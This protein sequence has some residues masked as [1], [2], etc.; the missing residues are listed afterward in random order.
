[1]LFSIRTT[2][3]LRMELDGRESGDVSL[4]PGHVVQVHVSLG[5]LEQLPGVAV[6]RTR[7]PV[8]RGNHHLRGR[9]DA[10]FIDT[11]ELLQITL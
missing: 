6:V 7:L 11:I 8:P 5:A 9:A 4:G 2:R 10:I 1:M 3:Y